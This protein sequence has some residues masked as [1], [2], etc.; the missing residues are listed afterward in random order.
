MHLLNTDPICLYTVLKG[1]GNEADFPMFLHKSV[2]HWSLTL[3]FE[4]YRF[5]LQIRGD[6]RNRI[7]RVADSDED[8]IYAKNPENPPR[9]LVPH[10]S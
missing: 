1:H 10:T 7:K 8:P 2:R 9:C 4:P 6:I 3:H 5:W